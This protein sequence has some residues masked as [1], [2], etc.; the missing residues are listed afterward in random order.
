MTRVEGSDIKVA[1]TQGSPAP[2]GDVC[3]CHAWGPPGMEGVGPRMLLGPP[4]CSGGPPQNDLAL[5]PQC[6]GQT[7]EPPWGCAVG[8]WTPEPLW[9]CVG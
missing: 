8:G 2:S 1:L 3:G 9:G 4:E 6:P 7:P 5:C